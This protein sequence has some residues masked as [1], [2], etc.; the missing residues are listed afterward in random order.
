MTLHVAV[1]TLFPTMIEAVTGHGIVNRA[2]NNGLLHVE[3]VNPRDFT[4]D[5]HKTVDDRP[6]GGGPGMVMKI[7]PLRDAT[8]AACNAVESATGQKPRVIYLSPQGPVLT[9]QRAQEL[10][11]ASGLVLIAGRYEGVD[12][13]FIEANVDEELSIGD[14][15]LSG[16]ELAAMVLIDTVTRLLPGALGDE[17][18]A[19]QDS[20]SGEFSGLLDCPH[21]TRPENFEGRA[22]PPVLMSGNHAAIRRWRL[23]QAL[24]RTQ[25]RRPDLF[26]RRTAQG[27]AKQE[28]Q[29][30]GEY[31]AGQEAK[32]SEP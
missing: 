32:R 27:L 19:K 11:A 18:S 12:E 16:G 6:F 10:A 14:Y 25:Q 20:F 30:L 4:R 26:A 8:S 31:I 22:V 5:V 2:V 1:V 28:Q 3:G 24:G 15:V 29:L 7:E 13:R 23:M 9:Q 17:D 21:Y